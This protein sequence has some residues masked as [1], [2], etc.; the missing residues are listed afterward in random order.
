MSVSIHDVLTLPLRLVRAVRGVGLALVI[1]PRMWLAIYRAQPETGEEV[2]YIIAPLIVQTY[3]LKHVIQVETAR[4]V[5]GD[6]SPISTGVRRW[7]RE[8]TEHFH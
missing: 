7:I 2:G 5:S 4:F 3:G 6:N 8:H 1:K